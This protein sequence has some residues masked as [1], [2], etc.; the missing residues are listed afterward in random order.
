VILMTLHS[1]L[2]FVG[3]SIVL[4]LMPGPDMI[5]MLS[6]CIAQGRRAGLMAAI[7][8]NLGSYVHLMAAA[9]K[10]LI[11]LCRSSCLA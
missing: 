6:R 4:V 2:L 7:G 11:P 1:Y 10:P 8:F 5:Y 3:A 9:R